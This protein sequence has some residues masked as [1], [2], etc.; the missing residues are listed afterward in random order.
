MNAA[1]T[2]STSNTT[3][4]GFPPTPSD[5]HQKAGLRGRV[6]T[7]IKFLPLYARLA[8]ERL[9]SEAIY[10]NS[11]VLDEMLDAYAKTYGLTCDEETREDTHT[12]CKA[13]FGDEFVFVAV[14]IFL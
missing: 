2:Q 5:A 11:V 4:V 1:N 7:P 9:T 8:F 6:P 14:G 12:H 13:R 3:T 10:R